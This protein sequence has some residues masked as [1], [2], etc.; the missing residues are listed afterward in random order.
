VK[1]LPVA[2]RPMIVTA[3]L[4]LL[5]ELLRLCAAAGAEAQVA[6]DVEA[7]RRLWT[8]PPLVVVGTDLVAAVAWARLPRRK[9]VVLTGLL[10][11]EASLWDL[12]AEISAESIMPL[13]A[14][15]SLLLERFG[16]TTEDAGA[17]L[18][19]AVVGG[20]GGAGASTFAAAVSLTAAA[21]GLVATLV[22]ADPFGGGIDLALGGEGAAGLRWSDIAS[23]GGRLSG[24]ALRDALPRIHGMSVLSWD[25]SDGLAVQPAAMRSVLAAAARASDLVTVDV[26]RRIDA[27][28]EQALTAADVT[29]LVLPAEVRAIAAAGRVAAALARTASDVRVVVRGPAPSGLTGPMVADTLHLPLAGSMVAEPGLDVTLERGQPPTRSPRGPLTVFCRSFLSDLGLTGTRAA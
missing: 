22:D 3:D 8:E 26:P 9:G 6:H 21:Q 2:T 5:D 23:G 1:D 28:A 15:Q 18:T 19:L 4:E 7:A 24:A 17:G 25:R 20:R 10:V 13:P 16:E 12:A 11:S 29:V 14:A 27:T